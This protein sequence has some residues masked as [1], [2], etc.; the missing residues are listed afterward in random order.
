MTATAELADVIFPASTPLEVNGTYVAADR[1]VS[2]LTGVLNPAGE[3]NNEEII[4]TLAGA[5]QVNLNAYK[6]QAVKDSITTAEQ[7]IDMAQ[8]QAQLLMPDCTELFKTAPIP[9]PAL[10]KF[11]DKL[12]REGLK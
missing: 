10:K 4:S 5:M 2:H 7:A 9:N 11:N 3:K 12:A 6:S 8:V 1:K